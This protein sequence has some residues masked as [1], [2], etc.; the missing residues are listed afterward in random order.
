MRGGYS[1]PDRVL[2]VISFLILS[3]SKCWFGTMGNWK[4]KARRFNYQFVFDEY[5]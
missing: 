3:F 1:H 5:Q 4:E 2:M